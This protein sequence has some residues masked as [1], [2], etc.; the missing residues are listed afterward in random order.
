M[1]AKVKYL[2]LVIGLLGDYMPT[3]VRLWSKTKPNN[4]VI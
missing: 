3:P 4:E 2:L 1:S